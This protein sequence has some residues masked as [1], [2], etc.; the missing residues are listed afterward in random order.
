MVENEKTFKINDLRASLSFVPLVPVKIQLFQGSL[1]LY[2]SD[3]L[4]LLTYIDITAPRIF[5]YITGTK[6]IYRENGIF[7]NEINDLACSTAKEHGGTTGTEYF[8]CA[9]ASTSCCR[10]II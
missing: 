3:R 10:I 6:N 5:S 4:T 8:S 9:T 2:I 7:L 1:D